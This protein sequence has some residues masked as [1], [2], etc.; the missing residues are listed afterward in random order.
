MATRE[1]QSTVC[2]EPGGCTGRNT[3]GQDL[4]AILLGFAVLMV[5]MDLMSESVSGL[6]ESETFCN[7]LVMFENPILG[8]LA[9]LVLTAIVQ[10]SSAS[11]GILQSLTVTKGTHHITE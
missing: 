10:S 11:V 4:G 8:I 5:G 6:K 2:C 7:L 9:G 1:S 3:G